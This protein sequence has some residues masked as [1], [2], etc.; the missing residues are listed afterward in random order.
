METFT[1]PPVGTFRWPLTRSP[2]YEEEQLLWDMVGLLKSRLFEYGMLERIAGFQ[3]E[4]HVVA[5][6]LR[7][8]KSAEELRHIVHQ[9]FVAGTD[10]KR[11]GPI[12]GEV[13]R[14]L[15]EDLW[16]LACWYKETYG[17]HQTF[18]DES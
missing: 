9:A 5:S 3:A 7:H 12:Q 13:W 11:V 2:T 8:T 18:R 17:G 6:Q 14:R 4:A 10:N 15:A 16:R 1:W